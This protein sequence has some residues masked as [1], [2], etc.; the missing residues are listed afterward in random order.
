MEGEGEGG[1]MRYE[2]WT[3]YARVRDRDTL[4]LHHIAAVGQDGQQQVG[5]A[6]IQQIDLVHVQYAPVRLR[7]QPWLENRLALL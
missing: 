1:L 5:D 2:I 7:Q 4:A 6:V 3:E